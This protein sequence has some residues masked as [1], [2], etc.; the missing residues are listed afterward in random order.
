MA[1]QKASR[2]NA[3]KEKQNNAK[4]KLTA[5]QVVRTVIPVIISAV[6]AVLLFQ[7][8]YLKTV[9]ST[10]LEA[11]IRNQ[12]RADSTI[13]PQPGRIVDAD[14]KTLAE[15]KTS[16]D[17]YFNPSLLPLEE[18]ERSNTL[19]TIA[20][21]FAGPLS[22]DAAALHDLLLKSVEDGESVTFAE[23]VSREIYEQAV[24]QIDEHELYNYVGINVRQQREYP[25]GSMFSNLLGYRHDTKDGSEGLE[26]TYYDEITGVPGRKITVQDRYGNDI[27]G[28][29]VQINAAEDG[30]DFRLTISA[31]IQSVMHEVLSK[32]YDDYNAES[33]VG[34]MI[35]SKT[36]AVLGMVTLP[37]FDPTDRTTISNPTYAKQK[38][39]E[40]AYWEA[41]LARKNVDAD[42]R[43]W[44]QSKLDEL[45]I[46]YTEGQR[47]NRVVTDQITPGSIFKV[48]TAA[49]AYEEG[50]A[51]KYLGSGEAN[52]FYCGGVKYFDDIG[53]E[54]QCYESISHGRL[55]FTG[56]LCY[57]CNLFAAQLAQDLG[58]EKLNDYMRACGIGQK[59]GIGLY[60]EISGTT[61][62]YEDPTE[63]ENRKVWTSLSN[64][65]GQEV[66]P[67]PLQM[68]MA[69][70]VIASGGKLLRP[71]I[72]DSVTNRSTGVSKK[73]EPFVKQQVF[74]EET[75]AFIRKNMEL[76]ATEGSGTAA[77][78]YIPG[79][80]VGGKTGTAEVVP[81]DE[82][83]ETIEYIASFLGFAPANDPEVTLLIQVSRPKGN[84]SGS[85][86]AVPLAREILVRTLP[87]L[88]VER[89]FEEVED[90]YIP[91]EV[92]DVI[93]RSVTDAEN[94]LS[95]AGEFEIIVKGDGD[96][97]AGQY[98]GQGRLLQK[99]SKVV[100][101]TA[102]GY[103]E[104]VVVPSFV[105]KSRSEVEA[106]AD[107]YDLN[108]VCE[109]DA[110]S[111]SSVSYQQD[112]APG[113]NTEPGEVITVTFRSYNAGDD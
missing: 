109:G 105:G 4:K 95:G 70:N 76:A 20:N 31:S 58:Y 107:S 87:M 32:A 80:H 83:D 69:G 14:G 41:R 53:R 91:A 84:H 39:A 98:P 12:Q 113:V 27:P 74:S 77:G 34:V 22:M 72:V 35:E 38:A 96:T 78:V 52:S 43:A 97:V 17:L 9:R 3:R 59:T 90:V 46:K 36:G 29:S 6:F 18:D 5:H 88:G 45:D 79:Y 48:I 108:V 81:L 100:V 55:D 44:Y 89:S 42:T 85:T 24:E 110:S 11:E 37:D 56:M 112:L 104:T 19:T 16:W 26:R 67:T 65:F 62:D 73:T 111:Y 47:K 28:Q 106:I 75:A 8:F 23:D 2:A 103:R 57:S 86:V 1:D 60:G 10:E 64:S 92:P 25:Y 101:Y 7:V 49:A 63:T 68:V 21:S 51:Q 54:I 15:T 93:G 94:V 50:I 33:V 102:A 71:Y 99:G 40:K 13:D 61:Y 66:A 82:S 30:S